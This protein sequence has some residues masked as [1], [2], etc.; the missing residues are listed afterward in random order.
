[1]QTRAISI[2]LCITTSL[3]FTFPF[4]IWL[5]YF[6]S[7]IHKEAWL[8]LITSSRLIPS[9]LCHFGKRSINDMHFWSLNTL[10]NPV[11]DFVLC[12][13]NPSFL[14]S[15]WMFIKEKKT[16][17]GGG[18][19]LFCFC[20][21]C[22]HLCFWDIPRDVFLTWILVHKWLTSFKSFV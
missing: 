21:T 4:S 5:F 6:C 8:L 18:W 22:N 20:I 17:H 2:S 12:P 14:L 9:L 13:P 3:T 11:Q 15:T 16:N 7:Q 19:F 1:M 10:K